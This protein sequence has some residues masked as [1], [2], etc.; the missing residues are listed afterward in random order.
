MGIS[1]PGRLNESAS[2]FRSF[3]PLPSLSHGFIRFVVSS[4]GKMPCLTFRQFRETSHDFGHRFL[5]FPLT[6]LLF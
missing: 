4:V 1:S 6:L 2:L 5:V 3:A